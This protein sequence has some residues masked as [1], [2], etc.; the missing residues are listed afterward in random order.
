M[1]EIPVYIR[2]EPYK[3]VDDSA[4]RLESPE[5]TRTGNRTAEKSQIESLGANWWG[6]LLGPA[7]IL[8]R[9]S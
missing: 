8:F 3:V 6:I 2:S 5:S 1:L 7:A 9:F 4:S